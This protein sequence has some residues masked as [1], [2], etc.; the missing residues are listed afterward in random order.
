[1]NVKTIGIDLAKNVFQVHGVDE[2]GHQILKKRLSRKQ[3]LPFFAN[4]P[5]CTI[6][7][8]ACGSSNYWARQLQRLDH[9]VYQM[10]PQYVKPYV[11][12]NKNDYNDAEAICEAVTRPNMRF[13]SIKTIEQQD[14][15]AI[16]RIRERLVR[17]RTALINQTRGLLREYGVFLPLGRYAF[18]ARITDVLEDAENELSALARELIADQV[19]QLYELEQRISQY[20]MRV[21]QAFQ[22]SPLCQRLAEVDGVGPMVATAMVAAVGDAQSFRNGRQLAAWLGLV[23]RQHSTG[24]KTRLLGISKRGNKY[25]RTLLIHGARA[26]LRYSQSKTDP[27]S[28]WLQKL[29]ERRGFNRACVALANKNA[30]ILWALMARDTAYQPAV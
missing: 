14:I 15:Q 4:L 24:G 5:H 3:F 29:S 17:E 21:N 11:K 6:G 2:K 10:S 13:V 12:S 18:R 8:E 1:M 23:P 7:I 25:L 16:H 26:V 19:A 22:G 20:D 9:D 28:R 27:R 30:R